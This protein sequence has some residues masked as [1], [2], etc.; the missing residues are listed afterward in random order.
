MTSLFPQSEMLPKVSE[1]W[2]LTRDGDPYVIEMYRRH[3]SCKTKTP[4]TPLFV[5]PGRKYV[6]MT[7]DGLACFSWL[8]GIS[9]IE[10]PQK[11]W[12]CTLFRNEGTILSSDL[13]KDAVGFI[14]S[15]EGYCRV[16]TLV[17]AAK[18]RSQNP[19]CCFKH[20]GWQWV[21]TSKN[22]K[23]IFALE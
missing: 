18:V 5:G 1:F 15:R 22:G 17:N 8:K 20:A 11:G 6:M 16:W 10:P 3:Y 19:G 14:R 7:G 4:K 13:I 23:L 21:G 2:H 9:D 12:L